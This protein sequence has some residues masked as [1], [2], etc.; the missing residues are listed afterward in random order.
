MPVSTIHKYIHP[1]LE[2]EE[3]L[4]RR[5]VSKLKPTLTDTNE[6]T[7]YLFAIDQINEATSHLI[8]P[9]FLDQMDQVHIDEKW[10]NIFQD[11]EGYLALDDGSPSGPGE[12]IRPVLDT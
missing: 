12:C 11:G 4:I 10:F 7:R 2:D 9:K 6:E 1:W 3:P 8:R 5:V